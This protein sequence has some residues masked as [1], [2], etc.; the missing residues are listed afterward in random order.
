V[1]T[2]GEASST[3]APIAPAILNYSKLNSFVDTDPLQQTPFNCYALVG[4]TANQRGTDIDIDIDSGVG[5]AV[6]PRLAW[7]VGHL[8]TCRKKRPV[9]AV[10]GPARIVCRWLGWPWAGSR[11]S[12]G[13]GSE[14]RY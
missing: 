3:V 12:S 9:E 13:D 14:L 10:A 1:A 6:S 5:E 7:S 2:V 8:R 4:A 11:N